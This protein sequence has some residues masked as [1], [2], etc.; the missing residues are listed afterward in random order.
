MK[1]RIVFHLVLGTE[2]A[3]QHLGNLEFVGFL[4]YEPLHTPSTHQ[5]LQEAQPP[6]SSCDVFKLAAKTSATRQ[7]PAL[8]IIVE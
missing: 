8:N 3:E 4:N 2:T 5:L 1:A 6:I 7:R